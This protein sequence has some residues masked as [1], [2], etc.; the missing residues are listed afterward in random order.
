[1]SAA[2]IVNI[3]AHLPALARARPQ[4]LALVEPHGRDRAGRVRYRHFTYRELDAESDMMARGLE[5]V[6]IGHGVRTVLMLPPSLE[7]YALTFALFKMGAVIVLIDPG[8]GLR[9]LGVCLREAAPAAFIG[10]QRAH[11]ARVVLGWGHATV[12]TCVTVGTR[13]GWGGH[14][15]DQVRRFGASA[16]G[17]YPLAR[18]TV[19]ETCAI[20]FTSGSTG[21][22]KGVVYSHDLFAAQIEGLKRLYGIQP[23]EV[24]LPT[25]PLFGLFGPVLGLTSIIPEMDPTRPGNVD[26]VK[27][28]DAI[29]HFGVTNL[30]GSPALIRRVGGY[31]AVQG[32]KLPTLRRV[33]SAGAPVPARAVETFASLLSDGV[34]VHTPYGA[35]EALPVSSLGSTEILKETRF[36]TADGAGVCVG[37][38]APGM[39]VRIIR[40][41]DGPIPSWDAALELPRNEIGEI[42]VQGPAVTR[43]YHVRPEA[44]AL[45]KIA[46]TGGFWHRMGDVGYLDDHGRLW[47]CGRKSQRVLTASGPLF[48]VSCEGVFNAHPSVYRTALVG[49]PHGGTTEPVLC[50]ERDP[51]AGPVSDDQLRREL[52]ERGAAHKRTRGIQR[53]L[54]HKSF[55][56]DIRHNAK[57]SREQLAVWAAR[58][59]R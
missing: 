25:F 15:L 18:T 36:R 26:P 54:F 2:A 20:L 44:T 41:S 19:G 40:I 35:T 45:A 56:V 16:P 55:P 57:I 39:T 6:G 30:F 42:V 48:T 32:V 46:D 50:V 8:M 47:F 43:A 5:H 52:L 17:S 27:I 28:V 13:L 10:I 1:M 7:F 9:S 3:T 49:V 34:E 24:D 23:G 22:A 38:P 14:T 51:E 21:V 37:R 4:T 59:V 31:G 53:I 58:R 33:I 29:R 12:R 11:L